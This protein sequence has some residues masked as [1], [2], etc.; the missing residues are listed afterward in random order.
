MQTSDHSDDGDISRHWQ[1]GFT[2][3]VARLGLA[4]PNLLQTQTRLAVTPLPE[5][6]VAAGRV[7]PP[8]AWIQFL[9]PT[10]VTGGLTTGE[11][12]QVEPESGGQ[13]ES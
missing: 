3:T 12:R 5:A 7:T 1:A 2:G 13:L 6:M 10:A 8:E 4:Y 11:S 9:L